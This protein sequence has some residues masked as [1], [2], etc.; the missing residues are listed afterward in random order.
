M[1]EN[2]EK[3]YDEQIFPLMEEIIAICK[4]NKIPMFAEFEYAPGDF[5]RSV[6]YDPD[7][8]ALFAH[9]EAI[10]QCVAEGGINIDKYM[11]WVAKGARIKGHSSLFL[12]LAGI[13]V[14]GEEG[15]VVPGAGSVA[16]T[17]VGK[18]G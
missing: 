6:L 4:E 3:I 2:K 13:P 15:V 17:V 9:L 7:D 14:V 8:H 5:C 11:M 18:K 12:T 1:K 10:A 16:I